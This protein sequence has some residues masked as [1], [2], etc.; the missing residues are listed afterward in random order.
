MKSTRGVLCASRRTS[1]RPVLPKR[2]VFDRARGSDE[3]AR[4][5]RSLKSTAL[6]K[7]ARVQTLHSQGI[8]NPQ[9][10][11]PTRTE[12]N[13]FGT[14]TCPPRYESSMWTHQV[15]TDGKN[16]KNLSGK[17]S[18]LGS[19]RGVLRASRRTSQR[20]VLPKRII[21]DRVRGS[22]EHDRPARSR[23]STALAKRARVQTLHSQGIENPH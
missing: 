23:K 17:A 15:G 1:Q 11:Q 2:I 6:A 13:R 5:V 14:S 7:R 18:S 9:T 8:E 16:L 21:F 20:P 12:L 10:S 22:D 19:T 3:H 4:P